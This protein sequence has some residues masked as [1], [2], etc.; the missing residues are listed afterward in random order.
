MVRRRLLLYL[1][2]ALVHVPFALALPAMA[3]A[4]GFEVADWHA[5]LVAMAATA[6][7]HHRLELADWDRP[8]PTARRAFEELFWVHWAA[9]W[10]GLM[11]MLIAWAY[12]VLSADRAPGDAIADACAMG[13]AAALPLSVY[14]VMVRRRRV[15]VDNREVE[16]EGL[17]R[18]FDGWRVVQLSDLHFGSLSS[19]R[20][21]ARLVERINALSPQL[22]VLTGDYVTTGVR[23]HDDIASVL[24]ALRAEAGVF[25]VMGNHDY[26]GDG[27][28]LLTLLQRAGIRVLRNEHEVLTRDSAKLCL[29]GVDDVYTGR[30]DI[31]RALAG[32]EPA[33]PLVVL[34]HDP[35]S[36][37]ELAR[38]GAALVLSGH[39]H[40]GQLAVPFV[41]LRYNLARAFARYHAGLYRE[42][43][44]QL[45]VSPGLGTTGPPFRLGSAPEI[46][47]L[48]L[49]SADLAPH[50]ALL[51]AAL[52]TVD[53]ARLPA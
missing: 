27:E 3:R 4:V 51:A 48:V 7:L 19:K 1:A 8:I 41:A 34:A 30:I 52:P 13:Y 21:V 47:V 35:S 37:P 2:T 11:P 17:A 39:T 24:G 31:D 16:I 45:W 23:F 33:T 43:D 40:W 42:G 29:A 14:G 32:R 26:F 20:R 38:R 9:L 28:P 10:L 5:V 53:E 46:S 6:L 25:A 49:R 36:F 44:A 15:R 18:A 50:T 12:L 22:I